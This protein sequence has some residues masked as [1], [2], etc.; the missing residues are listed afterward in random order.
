MTKHSKGQPLSN[1]HIIREQI[2]YVNLLIEVCDARAPVSSRHPRVKE[3]F[4]DK[5]TLIVL[6]K[7][8][9][10]DK[11]LLKK[12]IE[13]FCPPEADEWISLS[14]K[15]KAKK[16]EVLR[17]IQAMTENKR[18]AQIAKGIHM[19]IT[20]I[21]VIGMPNV[22]K[23]SLINWLS[24]RNR[25]KVGD[26]PGITRGPQWI[27]IGTQTEL[28]DTPGVLPR[29]NL[30]K[31]VT[32]KLAML[33]LVT[34]KPVED[35]SLAYLIIQFFAEK[36]PIALK[37]YLGLENI[38]SIKEGDNGLLAL[39][40]KRNFL[41]GGGNYNLNRAAVTLIS[42]VRCGKLGGILLDEV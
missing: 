8:D 41:S 36:Y 40:Q 2:K 4:G 38:A 42:D 37:K 13:T 5:P 10:A 20:R 14:L 3:I 6:N 24:G 15:S 26:K 22:G 34:G 18:K 19:P 32:E 35:E 39:A 16:Q 30:N 11:E 7:V 17:L 23:S 25:A 27:K 31:K 1:W 9:L 29:D 12:N 33:N 28:L 21:C